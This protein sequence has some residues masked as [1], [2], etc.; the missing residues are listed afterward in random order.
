MKINKK[1]NQILKTNKARSKIRRFFKLKRLNLVKKMKI[2]NK[3][4]DLLKK[5]QYNLLNFCLNSNKNL[6]TKKAI[7]L[8]QVVRA[9]TV[10]AQ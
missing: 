5:I 10:L 1:N 8:S 6:K 2:E 4:K 3:K 7:N 9:E